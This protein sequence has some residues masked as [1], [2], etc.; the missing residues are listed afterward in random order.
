MDWCVTIFDAVG[1]KDKKKDMK[2]DN[3]HKFL[4][5]QSRKFRPVD[6]TGKMIYVV[7]MSLAI[8]QY[9][10]LGTRMCCLEYKLEGGNKTQ[11]ILLLVRAISVTYFHIYAMNCVEKHHYFE[12]L[13]MFGQI[14]HSCEYKR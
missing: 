1:C 3:W 4:G 2:Y 6:G 10:R 12:L 5:K 8:D 14:C 9:S 7:W 11:V 13:F